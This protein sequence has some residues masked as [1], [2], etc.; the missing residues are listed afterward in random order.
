M[1]SDPSPPH[2]FPEMLRPH[3]FHLNL[4]LDLHAEAP[5]EAE[6]SSAPVIPD[7]T[8]FAH[9]K[10]RKLVENV[11]SLA[12]TPEMFRDSM[13]TTTGTSDVVMEDADQDDDDDDEDDDDDDDYVDDYDEDDSVDSNDSKRNPHSL[14]TGRETL[15]SLTKKC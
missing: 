7:V 10:A 14:P 6:A 2:D 11:L 13:D 5:S 8:L 15:A 1:A 9:N 3:A 12:L 4:P